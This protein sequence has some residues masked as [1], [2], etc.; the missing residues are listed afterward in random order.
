MMKAHQLFCIQSGQ[1]VRAAFGV[2]ELNLSYGRRKHLHDGSDLA[3]YKAVFRQITEQC[4]N[5]EKFEIR[6]RVL[7]SKHKTG[8][9]SWCSLAN[10]DQPA[11][12]NDC[13]SCFATHP[14]VYGVASAVPI[15]NPGQCILTDCRTGKRCPKLLRVGGSHSES[16]EEDACFV[17]TVRMLRVQAI[18]C[19][20]F[21]RDNGCFTVRQVH[22]F[23]DKGS[24]LCTWFLP[25]RHFC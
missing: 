10:A 15:R 9:E 13:A 7:T 12:P 23:L 18:A 17:L 5:R 24:L 3:A 6:H 4:D 21:D 8:N 14:K 20:L 25:P 16:G 2:D 19:K 11:A 1:G 22:L